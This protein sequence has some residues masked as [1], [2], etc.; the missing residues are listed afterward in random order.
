MNIYIGN[1]NHQTTEK[2]LHDLF[3][4]FGVIDASKIITKQHSGKSRGYGFIEMP[5]QKE[6]ENA[7]DKLNGFDVDGYFIIVNQ[8]KQNNLTKTSM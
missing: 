6:A 8:A 2:Q 4:T 5:D 3:T 1:L 7:I